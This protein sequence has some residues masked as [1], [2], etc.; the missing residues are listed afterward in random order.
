MDGRGSRPYRLTGVGAFAA[1]FARGRRRDGQYVQL[2]YLPAARTIGRAG[3]TVPKKL[4]P[5]AVERNRVRR[6]LR[7]VVRGERPAVLA[8]D[9]VVRL[10]RGCR[11]VEVAQAAVETRRLLRELP[12]GEN[13]S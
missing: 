11:G 8:F 7:E 6:V 1:L 12:H 2:V 13:R 3:F 5:L 4:L 9:L 10:K